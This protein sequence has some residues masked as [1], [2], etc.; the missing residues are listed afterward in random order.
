LA[1]TVVV[2]RN[3]YGICHAGQSDVFVAQIGCVANIA[4]TGLVYARSLP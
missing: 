4:G 3:V 2:L 1:L